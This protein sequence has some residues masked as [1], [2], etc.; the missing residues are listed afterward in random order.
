MIRCVEVEH[1]RVYAVEIPI[2]NSIPG[3]IVTKNG[4]G[5]GSVKVVLVVSTVVVEENERM[6]LF[7]SLL[8]V[9]PVVDASGKPTHLTLASIIDEVKKLFFFASAISDQVK[10]ASDEMMNLAEDVSLERSYLSRSC[11]YPKLW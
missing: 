10:P 9:F 6:N 2:V 8:F 7:K 3:I 5:T 11:S 4:G 1:E